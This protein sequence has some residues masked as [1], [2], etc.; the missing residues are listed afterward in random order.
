MNIYIYMYTYIYS[1]LYTYIYTYKYI[2]TA[3]VG[4]RVRC[5]WAGPGRSARWPSQARVGRR[6]RTHL[7]RETSCEVPR[8]ALTN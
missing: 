5:T 6:A 8:R 3:R 7:G 4:M 2:V 1:Y